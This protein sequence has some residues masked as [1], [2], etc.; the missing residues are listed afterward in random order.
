MIIGRVNKNGF[1][2]ALQNDLIVYGGFVIE[3]A[4]NNSP[5]KAGVWNNVVNITMLNYLPLQWKQT[6]EKHTVWK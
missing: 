5:K 6:L 2:A 4:L 3:E 1:I